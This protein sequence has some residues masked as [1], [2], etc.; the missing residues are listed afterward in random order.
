MTPRFR[1][2]VAGRDEFALDTLDAF[3]QKVQ[4]GD[5]GP[6]D[7]VF[8][9]LTG[10]WVP[11]R[12]HPAYRLS[13]DPLVTQDGGDPG[14]SEQDASGAEATEGPVDGAEADE[15]SMQLVDVEEASPEEEAR[16]FIARME[17]E[18]RAEEED[19]PSLGRDMTLVGRE[20]DTLSGIMP[21]S[22]PPRGPESSGRSAPAAPPFNTSTAA[23]RAKR[24]G[25]PARRRWG[26][27]AW[28]AGVF[29]VLCVGLAATATVAWSALRSGG[30]LSGRGVDADTREARPV[31]TTEASVRESAFEGFVKSVE[32]LR[33][34]MGVGAVPSIWLEGRYL[35][36]PSV[37]PQVK[38]YWERY[39][40]FVESAH[41]SEV[42][43][44][45]NA[46]LEVADRAGI[47][48][49]MRSLRAAGAASDFEADSAARDS[50]Y[51]QVRKLATEALSLNATLVALKGRVSYEPSR[52][53][54]L[55]ADPVIEAAGTDP[56]A[57]AELEQALDRVLVAIAP[58]QNGETSREGARA[59]APTWLVDGMKSLAGR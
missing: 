35:A 24:P 34:D 41:Q 58:L 33:V 6:D 52:G 4:E 44:Y 49:P 48:G 3:V 15:A 25:R 26:R 42:E 14:A 1:I 22:T 19:A 5:V 32:R 38:E 43:L 28:W 30:W 56:E 55:S 36:D 23:M 31:V 59:R 17:Q 9:E 54:R 7:L 13:G 18:R 39:L 2:R 20:S 12:S 47:G 46:Y 37:Y 16:E 45:R 11:A 53:E 21:P 8:D 27:W 40:R 51:A 50:L 29:A 10:E 57:Q